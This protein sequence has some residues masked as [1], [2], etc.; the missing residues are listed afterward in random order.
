MVLQELYP[1]RV[2]L[3]TNVVWHMYKYG[4]GDMPLDQIDL[5][6]LGERTAADLKA[7][8]TIYGMAEQYQVITFV[9]TEETLDELYSKA[10]SKEGMGRFSWGLELF[11]LWQYE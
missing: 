3:D 6:N 4:S 10:S 8:P 5:K 9:T 2:F 1:H 11:N 7:L